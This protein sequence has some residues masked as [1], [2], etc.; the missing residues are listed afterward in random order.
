MSGF[1]Y[2][3]ARLRAMKSR[4]FS[5]RELVAMTEVDSLQGLISTLT[6]TAYRKP[7][8]AALVRTSGKD[9]ISEALR[10]DLINTLGKARNFFSDNAG[11]MV[12]IVLRIYDVNNLK[13]VLRGLEKNVTPVEVLFSILPIGELK[14]SIL[15]ELTL[16]PGPRAAVDQMASMGLSFAQPLLKVRAEF[17]GASIAEMELALDRWY[18]QE[19]YKY[20]ERTQDTG[21]VL[22]P[23]IQLEADLINLLTVLRFSDTPGER[24]HLREF[25]V[26]DDL[27]HLFVGPGKLPFSL[28][29]R[30]GKQD[31]VDAAVEAFTGT[32]YQEPLKTGL[33]LFAKSARLSE[34]ERQLKRYRL[35]WMAMQITNDPLGIGV[36][37]GYLALKNNEINNIR[38]IAEGIS[39]GLKSDAIRTSLEYLQ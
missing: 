31:T 34:F 6:K 12:S 27:A 33:D 5:R 4:L 36:L 30:A 20:S 13:A 11:E 37:L 22:L 38:W 26:S 1:D 18:F 16:A 25:L 35:S 32:S 19:V 39:L 15:A 9:C 17:P 28:L 29:A 7:V 8:E 23:A 21:R 3:N 24:K 14:E 2:G 10:Q